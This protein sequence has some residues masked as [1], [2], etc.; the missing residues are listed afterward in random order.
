MAELCPV[1]NPFLRYLQLALEAR[2][3]DCIQKIFLIGRA[4]VAGFLSNVALKMPEALPR[5][6]LGHLRTCLPYLGKVPIQPGCN[7]ENKFG[8][9]V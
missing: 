7:V 9:S 5:L 6:E 4:H 1:E 2:F 8:T 3:P